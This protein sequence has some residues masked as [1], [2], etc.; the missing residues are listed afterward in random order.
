MD[1]WGARIRTWVC[2]DQNPVPYR[3]ATP[4]N[5]RYS[6]AFPLALKAGAIL[7]NSKNKGE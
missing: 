6:A 4:Q 3:L 1:G 7:A 5:R 2:G